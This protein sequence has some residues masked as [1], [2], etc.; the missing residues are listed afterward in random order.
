MELQASGEMQSSCLYVVQQIRKCEAT[1]SCM[2]VPWQRTDVQAQKANAPAAID[3]E[4]AEFQAEI[5]AIEAETEQANR[6]DT[7]PPEQQRFQDDDGTNYV[8]DSTLR[9]FV[10][11]AEMAPSTSYDV[12]DMVYEAEDEKIPAMPA[13]IQVQNRSSS[14]C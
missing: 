3:P 4:L 12:A 11:A 5:G 9:R 8:W 2:T 7:P 13:V 14:S 6:A 10:P 1:Q